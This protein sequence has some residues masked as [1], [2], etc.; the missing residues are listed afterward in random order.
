MEV[1]LNEAGFYDVPLCAAM[2]KNH[3][4]TVSSHIIQ[5]SSEARKLLNVNCREVLKYLAKI[6][7]LWPHS[8]KGQMSTSISLLPSWNTCRME[9]CMLPSFIISLQ[10]SEKMNKEYHLHLFLIA[11]HLF[12]NIGKHSRCQLE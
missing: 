6:S 5:E 3:P 1:E 8:F 2:D 11:K 10:M 4:T 12:S 9:S 7:Q